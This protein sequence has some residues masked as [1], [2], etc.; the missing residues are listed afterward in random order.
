MEGSE[1]SNLESTKRAHISMCNGSLDIATHDALYHVAVKLTMA[2]WV[3]VFCG[4]NS[5]YGDYAPYVDSFE[6]RN[7]EGYSTT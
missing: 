4:H 2:L 1:K 6:C 3:L 5:E 7:I